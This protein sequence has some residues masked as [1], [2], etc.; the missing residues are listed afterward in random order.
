VR[1]PHPRKRL[2]AGVFDHRAE[3]LAGRS[4]RFLETRSVRGLLQEGS[5][6]GE[7]QPALFE[8]TVIFITFD[9]GGGYY[10]SG[11]VLPIDF[12]GDGTRIPLIAVSP[13]AT[14]GYLS[15]N[16]ADHVSLLKFVERNWKLDPITQ[17][18]RDNLPNPVADR[19][20]PW[21][22]KNRPALGDLFDLFDFDGQRAADWGTEDDDG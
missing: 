22:P 3:W 16:Y 14:N 19:T 13:F 15:H 10:D 9:E 5:R 11:F 20:N 18:S 7:R 1:G 12:F 17:R 8:D 6:C 2:A 4:P 21:V